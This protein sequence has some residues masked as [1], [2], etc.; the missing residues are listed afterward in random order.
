MPASRIC[1]KMHLQ[2]GGHALSG[3]R[4]GARE[5]ATTGILEGDVPATRQLKSVTRQ[6]KPV[7]IGFYCPPIPCFKP[8]K[9]WV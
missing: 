4:M 8:I 7:F 9:T 2:A 5:L 3:W 1:P 6:L